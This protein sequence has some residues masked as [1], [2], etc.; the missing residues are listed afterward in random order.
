[1]QPISHALASSFSSA[2]F[3]FFTHSILGAVFCFITGTVIDIDHAIDFIYHYG[4]K[5]FDIKNLFMACNETARG[6]RFGFNRV[7][8][9]LHSIEITFILIV[10]SIYTRNIL[11]IGVSTGYILHITMD[12]LGNPFYPSSYFIFVRIVKGFKS[13]AL[14]K[15]ERRIQDNGD[16]GVHS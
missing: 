1:M 9:V 10:L 11:L 14:F 3:Y 13:D 6:G 2:I 15:Q 5:R 16:T 7:F 12:L 8:I 4:W